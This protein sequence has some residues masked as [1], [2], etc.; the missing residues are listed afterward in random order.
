MSVQHLDS[1][2]PLRWAR[3]AG[4]AKEMTLPLNGQCQLPAVAI[5][6]V[7]GDFVTPP[8]VAGRMSP[9]DS[10]SVTATTPFLTASLTKPIV[11]MGVLMLVEQGRFSLNDRLST[12]LSQTFEDRVKSQITVRH[13]L[14]HTSGLPDLPHNNLELRQQQAAPSAFV[15]AA[16]K[17]PLDFAP[18]HG[19]QYSSLGYALLGTLIEQQ[20]GRT[21]GTYLA[22]SIF[23]PLG[24]TSTC[25]ELPSYFGK[26]IA[27]INPPE[28]QVGGDDWNWNSAYWRKF[29]AAW[30]GMI[31]TTADLIRLSRMILNG[32]QL[33]GVRFLSEATVQ[34][35]G[36]NQLH[37]FPNL[38]EADRRAR[39]W[40]LGWRSHWRSHAAC[41]GDFLTPQ[42]YGHWGA[43]GCLW[44]ID[45][46]LNAAAVILST[47]PLGQNFYPLT[48]LSNA[49]TAAC[50]S[51]R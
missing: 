1:I 29:G 22:E 41:F 14:T 10:A 51:S 43:T 27:L 31:S 2:D 40:G 9:S 45:P 8:L 48:R 15:E 25:L 21:C 32:G 49:V 18:G 17:S 13:L 26:E 7:C 44:W 50:T 3:V 24:M 23:R 11:A 37:D 30:G 20:T 16:L 28:E 5:Q 6:A 42:A 35:A 34:A 38:P 47:Q 12:L 19:L 46:H 4:L 33:D 39:G 36:T